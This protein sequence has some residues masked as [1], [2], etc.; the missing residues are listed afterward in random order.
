VLAALR[1]AK[2]RRVCERV[3]AVLLF[4]CARERQCA[5]S[6]TLATSRGAAR[7]STKHVG[8]IEGAAPVVSRPVATHTASVPKLL[9]QTARSTAVRCHA[10]QQRTTP[11]GGRPCQRT[12]WVTPLLPGQHQLPAAAPRRDRD[13]ARRSDTSRLGARAPCPAACV[14]WPPARRRAQRRGLQS[15]PLHC[16]QLERRMAPRE[17]CGWSL[18]NSANLPHLRR[19]A[20]IDVP[21][22]A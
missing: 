19:A 3:A 11:A 9:W 13:R 16:F 17:R 4:R 20:S 14:R 5:Q 1:R 21:H 6:C 10:R 12:P 8:S 2:Q 7:V 18:R 15:R 22:I